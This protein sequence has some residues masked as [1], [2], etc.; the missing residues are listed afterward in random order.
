MSPFAVEESSSYGRRATIKTRRGTIETP[1]LYP[2]LNFIAGTTTSSG[3]IW[4]Y[5]RNKIMNHG[6]APAVM[7]QA[8]G[9]LDYDL[10]ADALADWRAGD[11]GL[12]D[13]FDKLDR[14][15][16]IDSGGFKLMNSETFGEPPE[17]GGSENPWKIYTNPESILDLQTDYGADIIATLDYPIPP[18]LKEDEK[19]DRME[20]SIES[21]VRCLEL[22]GEEE[23][24]PAVY[25]AIHGH[26]YEDIN[27]YV[28]RFLERAGEFD[29]SFEGFAIGSL[30]PIASSRKVDI[31]VDIIQGAKHAIPNGRADD[32]ALHAF[33]VT[34]KLVP[35]LA[36]LGVDSFDSA[37]YQRTA[38]YK[39]FIHPETWE[40]VEAK[41]LPEDWSCDC[42]VCQDLDHDLMRRVLYSDTAYEKIEGYY[43]SQFYADI[44]HHNYESYRR[45][46][47]RIQEAISNDRLLQHVLDIARNHELVETGLKHAQL[48]NPELKSDIEERGADELV[49]G[50]DIGTFQSKLTGFTGET[51]PT[52]QSVRTISLKHSSSDFDVLQREHTPPS[53][54]NILLI[55]P[56]SQHKPYRESRTQRAVLSEVEHLR[57]RLHKVTVSGLYGPVPEEFEDEQMILEYEYVLT[58]EDADQIELVSERLRRYLSEFGDQ[59]DTVVGYT[60]S[61]AYRTVIK[62]A[63]TEYGRGELFPKNPQSLQLTEHFRHEN[64]N[65]LVEYLEE[66][67]SGHP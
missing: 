33:G 32:I 14:P 21:A 5:T 28:G 47:N 18:G 37:S 3:G 16:F 53:N 10:S 43:K 60:T 63:L 61:K 56:C 44:A 54:A 34:G 11:S 29:E 57:D 23:D 12:H 50:P 24:P 40:K 31:L 30:V 22:L 67:I 35:L 15:L 55:I 26:N 45:E 49:A 48:R 66:D 65:Q 42:K 6:C 36:L 27:W 38:Q 64:I 52:E 41:D 8:M 39:N 62:N 13:K 20:R 58:T 4:K 59:F 1:A 46:I 7:M 9:F 17:K 25:I 2:V 19:M 51:D